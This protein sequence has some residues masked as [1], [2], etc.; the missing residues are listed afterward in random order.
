MNRGGRWL[1]LLLLAIILVA[2]AVISVGIV[3]MRDRLTPEMLEAAWKRWD[4]K[5]PASYKLSYTIAR[6]GES[7]GLE[8]SR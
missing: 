5:G 6:G 7:G 2:P 4:E 1:G 3:R 8:A